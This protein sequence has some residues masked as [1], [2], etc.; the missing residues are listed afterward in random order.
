LN[1]AQTAAGNL[2]TL[3][4]QG[5]STSIYG[6]GGTHFENAIPELNAQITTVGN[7]SGAATPQP[8]VFLVTDG[9]DNNQ[10]YDTAKNSWT[11]SQPKL[12]DPTQCAT[13]KNRGI[14][15][16]VLYI[17]YPPINPVNKNFAGDEDDK[18][19]ALLPP[20]NPPNIPSTLKQCASPGFFY[21]AYTPQ[22]ITNAMQDMFAQS[23]AAARLTQ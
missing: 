23:L 6:S 12:M 7:G 18:V 3:L 17:P 21:S 19:N 8:F 2:G 20:N 16:S 15:V 4:D 9:A 11:G 10:H 13:F 22:D 1:G 5:Q 14:T